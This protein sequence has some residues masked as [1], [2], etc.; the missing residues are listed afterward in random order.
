MGYLSALEVC[1]HYTNPRL[2]YLTLPLLCLLTHP[3]S[4]CYQLQV[5][6][7]WCFFDDAGN[8]LMKIYW[9]NMM[10]VSAATEWCRPKIAKSKCA[11]FAIRS[12]RIFFCCANTVAPAVQIITI[13][14]SCVKNGLIPSDVCASI[15]QRCT[16]LQERPKNIRAQFATGILR[17]NFCWVHTFAHMVQIIAIGVSCVKKVFIAPWVCLRIRP[18]SIQHK[19]P[20]SKCAVFARRNL[21][22]VFC[23]LNTD[24][25]IMIQLINVTCVKNGLTLADLCPFIR[26]ENTRQERLTA[27]MCAESA[28]R[29]SIIRVRCVYTWQYTTLLC[30]NLI[31][32]MFVPS[33]FVLIC[34]FICIRVSYIPMRGHISVWFVRNRLSRNVCW[35]DITKFCT[36]MRNLMHVPSVVHSLLC[37]AI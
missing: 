28:T 6:V 8:F 32:V 3:L 13:S 35:T 31:S 5:I 30:V 29:R 2:P 15:Q 36:L 7:E 25:H 19:V 4:M 11:K 37:V 22:I 16:Q 23:C 1:R 20:K 21:Q 27:I 18:R 17:T 24:V 14:V 26:E 12:L 10:L 34:V 33:L 9:L